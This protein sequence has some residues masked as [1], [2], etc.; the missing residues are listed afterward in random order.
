MKI[1]RRLILFTTFFVVGWCLGSVAFDRSE[2][3][4]HIDWLC[5]TITSID[6][7]REPVKI[8][9]ENEMSF[10]L[11]QAPGMLYLRRCEESTPLDSIIGK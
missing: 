1:L 4:T 2:D 6:G 3:G 11:R 9:I 5:G 7:T 8:S 10:D